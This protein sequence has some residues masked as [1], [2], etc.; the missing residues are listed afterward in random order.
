MLPP[1]GREAML[2]GAGSMA[3]GK[4]GA[5]MACA[6]HTSLSFSS[7]HLI[8]SWAWLHSRNS[9]MNQTF[10]QVADTCLELVGYRMF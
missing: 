1:S 6:L 3:A 4:Q 9:R 2:P 7:M 8:H 10:C 5:S